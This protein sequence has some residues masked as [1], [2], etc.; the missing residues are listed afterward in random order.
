MES[1]SWDNGQCKLASSCD[2]CTHLG[3]SMTVGQDV[4]QSEQKIKI[5][6]HQNILFM[7]TLPFIIIFTVPSVV[8]CSYSHVH[9]MLCK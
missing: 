2:I 5:C 6:F 9:I 4:D 8:R 1:C 3:W 7:R